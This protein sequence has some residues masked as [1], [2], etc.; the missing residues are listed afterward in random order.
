MR[1]QPGRKYPGVDELRRMT[2]VKTLDQ[3]MLTAFSQ[4]IAFVLNKNNVIHPDTVA[5]RNE[6]LLK[7]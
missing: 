7:E 2:A 1:Q 6:I 5:A 3:V 4:S